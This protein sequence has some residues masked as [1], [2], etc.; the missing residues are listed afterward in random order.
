MDLPGILT[1][2]ESNRL[3]SS[4]QFNS[5]LSFQPAMKESWDTHIRRAEELASERGESKEL[6]TFYGKL[7]GTQKQIYEY[8]Q[9]RKGWR[10]SG[11]L[12]ED[13]PAVRSVIHEL[14][15][16]VQASGPAP[17]A[18]EARRLS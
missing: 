6:L 4:D 7:L 14:L 16:T 15:S 9:S 12:E 5:R 11:A 8:L 18:D 10:P 17:L 3:D 2:N 1:F 13:L